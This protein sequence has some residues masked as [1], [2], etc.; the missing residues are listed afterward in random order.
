MVGCSAGDGRPT[1]SLTFTITIFSVEGE[2]GG[3]PCKDTNYEDTFD[4]TT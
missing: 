3:V 4:R 2:W 1:A